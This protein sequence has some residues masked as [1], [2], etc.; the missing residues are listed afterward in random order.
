M[1]ELASVEWLLYVGHVVGM[2]G[3]TAEV[4]GSRL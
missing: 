1:V 4:L 2:S 3:G